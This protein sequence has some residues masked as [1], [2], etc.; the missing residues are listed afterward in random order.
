MSNLQS[1]G[2]IIGRF[3]IDRPTMGHRDLINEVVSR[4]PNLL[5]LLGQRPAYA[6]TN[7]PL[8]FLVR[9]RMLTE[10]YPHAVVLPV[11]DTRDD[12][13]WVTQ[14]DKLIRATIGIAPAT[15]Y[16]GRDS[17]ILG[18]YTGRYP[19]EALTLPN[20][21]ISATATRAGIVPIHSSD[22]RAGMI[23]ATNTSSPR[24]DMAVDMA[25]ITRDGNIILG[26]KP[27]ENKWR[28]PGGMFD[29]GQD[30]SFAHAA[31]REMKEETT[32]VVR[33]QDWQFIGDFDVNDWRTRD[34]DEH[35][36]R[37][38]F[39]IQEKDYEPTVYAKSDLEWAEA[40]HHTRITKNLLVEEH[41]M[42]WDALVRTI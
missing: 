5:I 42:L 29:I 10:L 41:H 30:A 23:Y 28:F 33:P 17:Q 12:E 35:V 2:V 13:P 7:N 8:P 18:A 20:E 25:V 14:V 31:T 22:F 11:E 39:F 27:G 3:Q 34:T 40:V 36:Y 9:M 37:T 1:W 4:H 19:L 6:N 38:M 15:L 26:R 21:H 16:A 32:V 24:M